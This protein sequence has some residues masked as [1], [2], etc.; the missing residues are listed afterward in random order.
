M[1][2][3]PADLS[4]P[5]PVGLAQAGNHRIRFR[6]SRSMHQLWGQFVVQQGG[7]EFVARLAH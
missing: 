3:R 7:K 6:H 4:A 5:L 2:E 1:R